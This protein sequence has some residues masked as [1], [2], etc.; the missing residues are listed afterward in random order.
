MAKLFGQ[1]VYNHKLKSEVTLTLPTILC[2]WLPY[3]APDKLWEMVKEV[4]TEHTLHA[5][6]P[7]MLADSPVKN[8]GAD[9]MLSCGKELFA[10]SFVEQ[11][12]SCATFALLYEESLEAISTKL[13]RAQQANLQLILHLSTLSLLPSILPQLEKKIT[14]ALT[15][16]EHYFTPPDFTEK[17]V[18]SAKKVREIDDS[19]PLL[20]ALPNHIKNA[21]QI[22]EQTLSLCQG[23]YFPKASLAPKTVNSFTQSLVSFTL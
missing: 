14:I 9:G 15:L 22:L 23:Y 16:S 21:E 8:V 13:A 18:E 12:A 20:L 19:L 7:P 11:V 6:P 10:A 3:F 1:I 17:L 2:R 5:L 4:D